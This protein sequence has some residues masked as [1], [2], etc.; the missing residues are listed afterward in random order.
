MAENERDAKPTLRP[1][2]KEFVR[3]RKFVPNGIERVVYKFF[4]E[5]SS[6]RQGLLQLVEGPWQ[7]EICFK[8]W[9]IG[10]KWPK[11]S[12]TQSLPVKHKLLP[13]RLCDLFQFESGSYHVR[14]REFVQSR[15]SLVTYGKQSL[16]YLGP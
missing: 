11:T 9:K 2:Y 5:H 3:G 6:R 4:W 7:W 16:R 1:F 10:Q 13:Q 15:F 8:L 12:E 14:K